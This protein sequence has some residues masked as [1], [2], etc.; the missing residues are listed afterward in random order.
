[1]ITTSYSQCPEYT[2]FTSLTYKKL[3]VGL[4]YM[5]IEKYI[6]KSCIKYRV[7]WIQGSL[8]LEWVA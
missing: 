7:D 6:V 3:E 4:Q 8:S 2:I 1:M 5:A